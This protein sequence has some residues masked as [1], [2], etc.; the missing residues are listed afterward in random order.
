MIYH[1]HHP[2]HPKVGLVMK[3]ISGGLVGNVARITASQSGGTVTTNEAFTTTL[4]QVTTLGISVKPMGWLG[5][6][7]LSDLL[8]AADY[9]ISDPGVTEFG[10]S[11]HLGFEWPVSGFKLRAGM[12]DGY[13]TYGVGMDLG[14]IHTN[15]AIFREETGETLGL[16]PATTLMVEGHISFPGISDKKPKGEKNEYHQPVFAL[17]LPDGGDITTKEA[18][19]VRVLAQNMDKMKSVELNG[20]PIV[21]SK[22]GTY[23]A[24][25][26]LKLGRNTFSAKAL[27][28]DL[29][30][31]PVA[32]A[33]VTAIRILPFS[34]RVS[35]MFD[36]IVCC[37]FSAASAG[38][39]GL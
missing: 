33:E 17:S 34:T 5:W 25:Q 27:S 32:S 35:L 26:V 6:D 37:I 1:L 31:G 4:P 12:N 20:Q 28:K 11:L 38:S 2:T 9:N 36:S 22:A 21:L 16:V 23:E 7:Q 39:K 15:M 10:R 19:T 14:I 3:N 8:I 24:S 29:K 30:R 18:V 13:V